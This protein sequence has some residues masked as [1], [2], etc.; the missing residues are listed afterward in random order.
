V[1]EPKRVGIV[2]RASGFCVDDGERLV[3]GDTLCQP[4]GC[5]CLPAA[6]GPGEADHEPDSFSARWP[7]LKTHRCLQ[8]R[9][10]AIA[11]TI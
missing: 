7:E 1:I 11:H 6:T 5:K 8:L 3:A 10:V 9:P 4:H 2:L